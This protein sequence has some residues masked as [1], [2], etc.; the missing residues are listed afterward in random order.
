MASDAWAPRGRPV[1]RM[2]PKRESP[3]IGP[4]L[5]RG[6]PPSAT[7]PMLIL[8]LTAQV[9][10]ARNT[11]ISQSLVEAWAPRVWK[12]ALSWPSTLAP[13]G[14]RLSVKWPASGQGRPQFASKSRASNV[15]IVNRDAGFFRMRRRAIIVLMTGSL[16]RIEARME[17]GRVAAFWNMPGRAIVQKSGA[18][19]LREGARQPR[20]FGGPGLWNKGVASCVTQLTLDLVGPREGSCLRPPYLRRGDV[21]GEVRSPTVSVFTTNP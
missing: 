12:R 16:G 15:S 11:S 10:S 20:A 17:A 4:V 3:W 18:A 7:T 21:L 6:C 13:S 14:T 9:C 8:A 1:R 5:P 2:S 19:R